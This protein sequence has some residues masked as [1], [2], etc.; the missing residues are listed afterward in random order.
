[1][2]LKP[3]VMWQFEDVHRYR[4]CYKISFH[5]CI[6][7]TGS[8]YNSWAI[9]CSARKQAST[10]IWHGVCVTMNFLLTL[11]FVIEGKRNCHDI[12]KNA[13]MYLT[14]TVH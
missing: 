6:G 4:D 8:Q 10:I 14:G 13:F 12:M 5:H 2:C 3:E 9:F 1:M 7:Y 11:N